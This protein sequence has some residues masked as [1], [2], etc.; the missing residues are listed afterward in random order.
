MGGPIKSPW[1]IINR[2][3]AGVPDSN[4]LILYAPIPG[5]PFVTECKSTTMANIVAGAG[6]PVLAFGTYL[7][8]ITPQ[9][10][11]NPS[12]GLSG[13]YIR[14]GAIVQIG[15]LLTL[16]P[17]APGAIKAYVTIPIPS[18]FAAGTDAGGT[19]GNPLADG[20]EI[21]ASPFV[22]LIELNSTSAGASQTYGF[23]AMYRILP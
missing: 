7:P 13:F 18:A 12:L 4:D 10:N 16:T 21:Q 9:T 14:I 6:V 8:V 19:F 11:L 15:G 2:A 3:V 20:G 1:E 23:S 5:T 17:T 22:N